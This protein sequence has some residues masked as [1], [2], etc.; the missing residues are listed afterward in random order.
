[1]KF[2]IFSAVSLS[3]LL[4]ISTAGAAEESTEQQNIIDRL[5]A[6]EL[7]L[8]STAAAIRDQN[9]LIEQIQHNLQQNINSSDNNAHIV[10]TL[11]GITASNQAK[12]DELS[13][14]LTENRQKAAVTEERINA[15]ATQT[16]QH[17]RR[18]DETSSNLETLSESLNHFA[19]QMSAQSPQDGSSE[20]NTIPL[21][22]VITVIIA[23]VVIL[24]MQLMLFAKNKTLRNTVVSSRNEIFANSEKI[25]TALESESK[26]T[27]QLCDAVNT[28]T[29]LFKDLKDSGDSALFSKHGTVDH[30]LILAIA[31]KTAFMETTL[32]KLDPKMRGY[33][34]LTRSLAQIKEELKLKGYEII[35]MLGK[36]YYDGMNVTADFIED[37][38]LPAGTRIIS[39]VRSPQVNYNGVMIQS[40]SITVSQNVEME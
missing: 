24:I 40:A 29:A 27:L 10:S 39:A 23:A 38:D 20:E 34:Q 35:D 26:Q 33:K 32:S 7:T 1:M 25:I 9:E 28:F 2:N 5:N 4:F 12:L 11:E 37:E 8:D 18:I 16:D 17:E 30:D 13:Q 14:N 21:S 19:A 36:K 22:W 31:N 15:L 3:F 6:L